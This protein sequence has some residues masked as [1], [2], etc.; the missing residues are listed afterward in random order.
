MQEV[1]PQK[2]LQKI[3]LLSKWSLL[4][5][6]PMM[7]A[8]PLRAIVKLT[9]KH[10]DLLDI[11]LSK[12]TGVV[13][14]NHPD[15]VQ[16]ILKTNQ[17]NYSRKRVLIGLEDF[18]GEGLF[19]SQG[20]LWEQQHQLLKPTFHDK[21]VR[22]YF[23][24]IHAE[25]QI[26]LNDWKVKALKKTPTDVE[27]DVNLLMLRILLKTQLTSAIDPDC[28]N[29]IRCLR[30]IL[31]QNSYKNQNVKRTKAIFRKL[32]FMAAPSNAKSVEALQTLEG[33]VQDIRATAATAPESMGLALQTLENAK[34]QGLI[35]DKQVRD[36]IMNF[37]FAGFD[38]TASALTW[39][40]YSFAK[41]KVQAN[42][43]RSEING[44]LQGKVPQMEDLP[45]MPY[46]KMFIQESI[47][48]YPPVWSLLRLSEA[49]DEIN[50]YAFPK[51]SWIMI[52]IYA[53]HRHPDFWEQPEK[54]DPKRFDPDTFKGK[55]FV[56]IPFGQGKR[57][58]VG[59]P[60]AMAELQI[61]LP[62]LLQH[63]S[64]A[65]IDKKEPVISADIIIKA[66]KPL[67]MQL[68]AVEK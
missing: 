58:C 31:S 22:D 45:K 35:S 1:E 18:L 38:T 65:L 52:C 21:F 27:Y 23:H 32:F 36:E 64:F 34:N 3:P 44:V 6:L 62:L 17:D 68:H 5:W 47:R 39:S 55:A 51:D 42:E 56:Y 43:L 13:L 33:I 2:T 10:G 7:Y 53:L 67:M 24:V 4:R 49:A 19:A 61:I 20:K 12:G 11:R 28:V 9:A 54:F 8:N 63:F 59:K 60:L 15:Y 66:K 37:I 25:T 29:I 41:N 46:T 50:G 40:L 48:L 14:V 26:L 30:L 57:A 16:R